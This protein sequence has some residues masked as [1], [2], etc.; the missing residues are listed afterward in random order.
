MGQ[1]VRHNYIPRSQLAAFH[2][3]TQRFSVLVCHRRAGKTVMVTND[4]VVRALRTTKSNFFGA[5][6]APYF[7]QAKQIAWAYFKQAVKDI[8]G[9]K[10]L[11]SDCSITFPNGSKIRVFGADNADSLR[12]LYF[13]YVAL[14]EIGDIPRRVWSEIIRPA[15]ADRM[16]SAVFLGTPKGKNFFYELAEK[17]KQSNGKWFYLCV[18]ADTSGIIPAGELAELKEDLDSYE[19][20]QEFLC[21]F[22]G[23]VRGSYYGKHVAF[24]EE[25]GHILYGEAAQQLYDPNEPVCVAHDP[26]RDDAWAIWFWQDINGERRYIDYWEES[27]YDAEEVLEVLNNRPYR[28][29]T[30]WVPHDALHRTAQS[31]RSI[32]DQFREADAPARKVPNPDQGNGLM[33]GVNAVRHTLRVFPIRFDGIRCARGLEA[34]RNYSRKWNPDTMV[35]SETPKHDQWSHGA[36]AFRYS[37]LTLNHEGLQASVERANAKR[38]ARERQAASNALLPINTPTTSWTLNDAFAARDAALRAQR[39]NNWGRW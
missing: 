2:S 30:W 24:L 35:F 37:C 23:A 20:N 28:Y 10:V 5:Y 11:E 27:G 14:D 25:R 36:D 9:M 19:Y 4:M 31:K 8:P 29:E 1:L 16:G 3:R 32:L 12:G 18:T 17:A 6:I 22:E 7:G 26:G 38:A 15:L 13:D 34:L 21:S 33:H 39:D